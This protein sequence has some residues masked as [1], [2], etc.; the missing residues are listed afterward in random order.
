MTDI[1]D[2]AAA[3][4]PKY[5]APRAGNLLET[6]PAGKEP[7]EVLPPPGVRRTFGGVVVFEESAGR[8]LPAA[9]LLANLPSRALALLVTAGLR[10]VPGDLAEV[11]GGA[12]VLAACCGPPGTALFPG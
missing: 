6:M 12:G 9:L 1:P 3:G 4:A 2:L 10:E 11:D 8:L 7:L 5:A